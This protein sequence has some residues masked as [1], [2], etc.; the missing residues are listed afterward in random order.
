MFPELTPAQAMTLM[1]GKVII[2]WNPRDKLPA[3]PP[4]EEQVQHPFM[5]NSTAKPETK[6][7][8]FNQTLKY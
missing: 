6:G 3:F 2:T 1:G 4:Q 8:S 7:G 5:V